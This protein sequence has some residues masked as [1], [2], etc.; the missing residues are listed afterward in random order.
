VLIAATKRQL[1]AYSGFAVE[2][3]DSGEYHY[4]RGKLQRNRE[5]I[6]ARGLSNNHN[7]DLQNLFKG[8]PARYTTSMLLR[9]PKGCGRRWRIL[10]WREKW[11][12]S[13]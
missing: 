9:L 11:L 5:R 6:T 7:N 3:R 8:V 4:V 1:R 12:P 2:T 13:L 10:L